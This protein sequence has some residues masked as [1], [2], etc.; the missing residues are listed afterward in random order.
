MN[1]LT[2]RRRFYAL[3]EDSDSQA[4]SDLLD[5][6]PQMLLDVE[7]ASDFMHSAAMMGRTDLVALLHARGVDVNIRHTE[8]VPEIPLTTAAGSDRAETVKWLI[9]H[10]SRINHEWGGFQPICRALASA[11]RNG[12]LE[13]SKML[14]E[15]DAVL[16]V[17]DRTGRT[18]LTWAHEYGQKEIADYLRSKG[19]VEAKDAPGYAE[20]MAKRK[21]P[22]IVD[23]VQQRLGPAHSL[24]W[25]P[26][27]PDEVPVAVN[28]VF[29]E[30]HYCLFTN[31]MSERAMVT[32]P[33]MEHYQFAELVLYLD[34]WDTDVNAWQNP[35]QLWAI[36]WVRRLT[37]IPFENNTWLGGKW[38]IISNEEPPQ[39]LSEFTDM[40][41]WLLLGEK[42]PLDRALLP[43]GKTVVFYT[44][45]PIHTG[46]R[47]YIL[48]EGL[49]SFLRLFEKYD[50]HVHLDPSRQSMLRRDS[51]PS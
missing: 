6:F 20:L 42:K 46:E 28:A 5:D 1:Y 11:V 31:G 47:D 13:I 17:L 34:D 45:M 39:P 51:S 37:Q 16:D 18:P 8:Q 33:E 30:D 22:P 10:G 27:I 29:N 43:D 32:P 24:S 14:V 40:T 41:C 7:C 9:E 4:I 44:L 23:C 12:N 48:R 19:A 3:F 49:V 15:A 26:I 25:L 36:N 50:V 38:T 2:Q 21:K 35:E